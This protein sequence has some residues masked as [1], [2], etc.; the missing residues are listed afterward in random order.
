MRYTAGPT[1][2]TSSR[3]VNTGL[4]G[5]CEENQT[6]ARSPSH[7][8]VA[9]RRQ[10]RTSPKLV[11]PLTDVD[12]ELRCTQVRGH[13]VGHPVNENNQVPGSYLPWP[14]VLIARRS[15][16]T[17][18]LV[19]GVGFYHRLSVCLFSA[20]SIY[21]C[22]DGHPA[23]RWTDG[24]PRQALQAASSELLAGIEG[25]RGGRGVAYEAREYNRPG[26]RMDGRADGQ[27]DGPNRA[28][29]RFWLVSLK[30]M[31]L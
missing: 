16:S 6:D 14:N 22:R 24:R 28:N 3:E 20:W 30:P 13:V 17:P 11:G 9:T 8:Q 23:R 27:A 15:L 26:R 4:I 5:S 21:D 1:R 25:S 7:R 31:Q 18:T 29:A 12:H 10:S 2:Q 19:A